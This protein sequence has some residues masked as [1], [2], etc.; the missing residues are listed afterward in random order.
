ME[1]LGRERRRRWSNAEKLEIVAAVGM[2]GE[3]LARVARRYDVSRSQIY[4]WRHLFRKRGLLRAADEPTFLPVDIGAPM[5]SAEPVVDDRVVASPLIIE[6]CLA[7]GRRLRF[8]ADIEAT[9]LTR[10]IRSVEAA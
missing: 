5:L 7:Q 9:A 4:Q 10:L 2:N 1:I 6:L 8:D 3:T